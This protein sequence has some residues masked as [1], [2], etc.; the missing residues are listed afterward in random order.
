MNPDFDYQRAINVLND[1][2]Y[3]NK[4]NDFGRCRNYASIDNIAG[5]QISRQQK[6]QNYKYKIQEEKKRNRSKSKKYDNDYHQ[7]QQK[8]YGDDSE[9]ISVEEFLEKHRN[10]ANAYNSERL[11]TLD[12]ISGSE[13]NT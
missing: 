9:R 7:Q 5:Q 11:E 8:R 10:T 4:D 3:N 2:N 6:I 12:E 1:H 13:D